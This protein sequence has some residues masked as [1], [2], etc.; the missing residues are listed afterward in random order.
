MTQRRDF[1]KILGMSAV[2]SVLP[3]V[4]LPEIKPEKL[5]ISSSG[6]FGIGVGAT[7]RMRITSSGNVVIA[8][9]SPSK[10]LDIF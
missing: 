10:K 4:E 9:V 1:L 6:H 5:T 2:A 8:G 3:K 7:E